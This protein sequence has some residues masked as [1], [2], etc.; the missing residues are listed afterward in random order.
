[1]RTGDACSGRLPVHAQ[2]AGAGSSA[3]RTRVV[4][5]SAIRRG[6]HGPRVGILDVLCVCLLSWTMVTREKSRAIRGNPSA[7]NR[8]VCRGGCVYLDDVVCPLALCLE[9]EPLKISL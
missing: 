8:S 9:G 3:R 4:I 5:A 1:M 7:K 2:F 6:R